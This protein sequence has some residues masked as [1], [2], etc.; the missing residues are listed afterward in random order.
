MRKS[1]VARTPVAKAACR[2]RGSHTTAGSF[3]FLFLI[4]GGMVPIV[5]IRFN[6]STY[7]NDSPP[8]EQSTCLINTRVPVLG[9]WRDSGVLVSKERAYCFDISVGT[10]VLSVCVLVLVRE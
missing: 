10:C 4:L 2:I 7:N 1:S 3:S 9:V 8:S 6:V 5:S